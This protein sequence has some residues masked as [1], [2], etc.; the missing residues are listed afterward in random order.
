MRQLQNH[1]K[2]AAIV[3]IQYPCNMILF[4]LSYF[5]TLKQTIFKIHIKI[6]F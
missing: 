3:K 6:V 4:F 5:I 1:Y 2:Y